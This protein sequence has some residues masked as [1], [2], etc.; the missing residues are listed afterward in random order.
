MFHGFDILFANVHYHC[1][2]CHHRKG[3]VGTASYRCSANCSANWDHQVEETGECN[4][5]MQYSLGVN[6]RLIYIL[7]TC[8]HTHLLMFHA[9]CEDDDDT[10]GHLWSMLA[11]LPHLLYS[12]IHKSADQ[13]NIIH[14]G[15]TQTLKINLFK[16]QYSKQGSL[17]SF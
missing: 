5:C 12:V 14:S 2:L 10:C 7:T 1:H 4:W 6:H 13:S 8:Y 11:T 3:I 17:L 16:M 15:K 9:D